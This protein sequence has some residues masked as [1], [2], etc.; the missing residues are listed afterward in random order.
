MNELVEEIES[1]DEAFISAITPKSLDGIELKPYSLM[2]QVVAIELTGAAATAL[3]EAIYVVWVCTL[4]PAEAMA[5]LESKESKSQA[6]FDAF[7]WAEQHG[8]TIMNSQ[9]ILT[10]YRRLINEIKASTTVRV[11]DEGIVPKN[12]GTLPG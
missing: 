5:T 9:P 11:A 2:R 10:I 8:I 12:V 6:R 4:E 3:Q 7:A 1:T